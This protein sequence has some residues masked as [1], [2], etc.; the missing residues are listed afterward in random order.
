[1]QPYQSLPHYTVAQIADIAWEV[2]TGLEHGG[3]Y[4]ARDLYLRYLSW[5]ELKGV[6]PTHS[7]V[8]GRGLRHLG[9]VSLNEIH[10]RM[11][12]LPGLD[13]YLAHE[14]SL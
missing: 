10:G 11:W 2:L 7:N 1:M 14:E 6:A 9:C 4:L 13:E 8:F 5:C 12:R 3:T